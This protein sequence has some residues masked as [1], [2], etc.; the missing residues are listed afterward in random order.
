LSVTLKSFPVSSVYNRFDENVG[1]PI[2]SF[3]AHGS[4]ISGGEA[5]LKRKDVV[6][7]IVLILVSLGLFHLWH[8]PVDESL[9]VS[10]AYEALAYWSAQRAYPNAVIP[11]VAHYAAFEYAKKHLR[12]ARW[13]KALTVEPWYAIGP[14]NL[15]GRTLAIAFDPQN[16]DILY[17]GSASGGLWRSRSGGVGPQAWEYVPTGFPLLAVS[18]I[19]LARGDSNTI[20][21]GT[22]EVYN[23]QNTE[24]LGAADRAMRG[25]Y[26]IGI[27]KTTDGG[28]TWSKSL[29]W[30]ANQRRGVQ[31]VK[32]DPSNPNTVWAATTEGVYKSTNGGVT[33]SQALNV[34]MA[35]D[36]VIHPVSLNIVI[37]ACGNF[38]SPGHGLY[39]TTDGGLSWTK[40]TQ[41]LPP[42]FAGKALLAICESAPNVVYASIANGFFINHPANATWLCKSLDSGATWTIESRT[43]YAQYQGWFSHDIA[44]NPLDPNELFAV[45]IQVWRSRTGG[46]SL[47]IRS[48]GGPFGGE[49]PP[50]APEGPPQYVHPDIHDV[51]YHPTNPDIVYFATDGGVFRTTN[52]G[53]NFEGCNGGYQT[54]QFYNGF[55]S[56]PNNPNLALGVMQD[57]GTIIY[58]GSTTWS[59]YHIGGD[60][61][62]TAID[63][64]SGSILYG[65]AQVLQMFKTEDGGQTWFQIAP[66]ADQPGPTTFIAPYVLSLNN[67]D[68]IYAGRDVI[69]KSTTGGLSWEV[70]NG[71]APLDGNPMLAMTISQQNSDVV[72]AASAPL[73]NRRAGVFRT[74]NGG[75]TWVNITANLPDRFPTDLTV[76]PTNDAI[77]YITFSGFGAAH[78]FK[79]D[80][81]GATWQDIGAALPDVPTSAVIVDPL[82]TDHLYVGNDIGVYVSTDGGR[83]WQ[84]F[85]EGL[86]E[87]IVAFDLSISPMN[88]KLRVATHGNGV[89]ERDL[90]GGMR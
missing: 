16:P 84:E 68:V 59:R 48:A 73:V 26:G 55:A 58:R 60:G 54:T 51:V 11:D 87:A 82:F 1:H 7:T 40:Q 24:V 37:A 47:A 77:V 23:Y 9:R 3:Q 81:G 19:A 38:S 66:G 20:Y 29:D 89:F 62:W 57:N 78:V 12:P 15:G 27:L 30:S 10:G 52:G 33:W 44:V 5:M 63:P 56:S 13:Q 4:F 72:Y 41:G 36:L 8:K 32:V 64:R 46:R 34:I 39:R 61:G 35:T 83:S 31:A 79:S 2:D 43:D 67:P 74:T 88:R 75:A 50:G 76:D 86:P 28:A 25:S 80:N 70:T 90:I 71:G 42:T 17:A 85:G 18:S 45:G 6:T 69:Y 14:H 49:I 21:I 22:G 53:S 65:S